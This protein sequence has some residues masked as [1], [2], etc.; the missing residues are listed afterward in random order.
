MNHFRIS[1]MDNESAWVKN[2]YRM[3]KA[4][5]SILPRPFALLNALISFY[6]LRRRT[7]HEEHAEKATAYIEYCKAYLLQYV[8]VF[9]SKMRRKA[10]QRK[11]LAKDKLQATL[12]VNQCR[13][14]GSEKVLDSLKIII[15]DGKVEYECRTCPK[16]E[17]SRR[18]QEERRKRQRRTAEQRGAN[19]NYYRKILG[20]IGEE[21]T[22]EK[23]EKAYREAV[24]QAHPD[25][26]GDP[27]RFKQV[28]EAKEELNKYAV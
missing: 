9:S 15:E 27:E 28:K 11:S 8:L 10:K 25:Q 17:K 22:K 1:G 5:N 20:L 13:E 26:G 19:L 7:E 18:E 12:T 21:L 23:V 16:R 3:E 6:L 4:E 2:T 24:K 14:C